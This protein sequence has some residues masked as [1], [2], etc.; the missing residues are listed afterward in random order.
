MRTGLGGLGGR[1]KSGEQSQ[2]QTDSLA[3]VVT[4]EKEK[5][6]K[7]RTS[8]LLKS[9]NKSISFPSSFPSPKFRSAIKSNSDTNNKYEVK[10]EPRKQEDISPADTS[11]VEG[12]TM[13]DGKL[14]PPS[15]EEAVEHDQGSNALP[16]T[17]SPTQTKPQQAV[18]ASTSFSTFLNKPPGKSATLPT[19][20]S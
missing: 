7:S 11:K 1:R 10:I 6:Y 9:L 2:P 12:I 5:S 13:Q 3:S 20:M 18:H 17:M 8:N 14:P 15:Y 4:S 16:G 19:S